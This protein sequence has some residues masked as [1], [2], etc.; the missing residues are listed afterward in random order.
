MPTPVEGR[1]IRRG[2]LWGG[3]AAAAWGLALGGCAKD[4]GPKG[5]RLEPSDF[6]AVTAAEQVE[7]EVRTGGAG[8]GGAGAEV[9][10]AALP[11]VPTR[12]PIRTIGRSE[13]SLGV[14]DVSVVPGSPAVTGPA[15]S[16]AGEAVTLDSKVGQINGQPIIASKFLEPLDGRLRALAKE[17]S[18][19]EARWREEAARVIFRALQTEILDQLLLAEAYAAMT[20][21]VREIGL[22]AF[23][24]QIREDLVRQ[25]EGSR[26][27]AN[28]RLQEREG[29]TIEQKSK[30]ALHQ[31]MIRHELRRK[32]EP[33]V[34]VSTREQREYYER[35][36]AEYNPPG[37][38]R[39]RLIRVAASDEAGQE[40]VRRALAEG[41][42]FAEVAKLEANLFRRDVGGEHTVQVPGL[43]EEAKIFGIPELND[44]AL[45]L[46]PGE[47]IGPI[48]VQGTVAWVHLEG[49]DRPPGVSFYD[50]Q[51]EIN[52]LLLDEKSAAERDRYFR[53]LLAEGSYS[54]LVQTTERLLAIATE[55]YYGTGT[56]GE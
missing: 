21:E 17:T 37:T 12:R 30:E 2:V 8:A 41:T 19:N 5:A 35:H 32:I 53:K 25:N 52:R 31:E 42:P 10:G 26:E 6:R 15:P 13:A 7:G 34:H 9:R 46:E 47:T 28:E 1:T 48:Q 55:R 51:L 44:A 38:A 20:P 22:R 49:I 45:A 4:G 36:F 54:D 39:L 56:R 18:G 23:M 24:T 3:A 43:Y 11:T 14:L 33:R 27:L 40:Q 50:A 29:V 16:P